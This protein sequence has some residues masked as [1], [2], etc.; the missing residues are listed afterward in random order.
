[1]LQNKDT[2]ISSLQNQLANNNI[3]PIPTNAPIDTSDKDAR[4]ADLQSQVSSLQSQL[5]QKT[6]I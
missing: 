5:N 1:M 3:T 6:L 2:E 4:I